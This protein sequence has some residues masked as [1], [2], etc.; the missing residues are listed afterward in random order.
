MYWMGAAVLL[1]SRAVRADNF[2]SVSYDAATDELVVALVYRGTN[3]NHTFS[4]KW[5]QCKD[6]Q[7]KS[8]PEVA[9]ELLDSQWRDPAEHT[10]KKAIRLGLSEMPCRPAKVTLR[11]APRFIYTLSIPAL[12]R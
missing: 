7:G 2:S 1:L 12:P 9:V 4:L 8:A 5:G 3:P 10:F 11:M 6:I